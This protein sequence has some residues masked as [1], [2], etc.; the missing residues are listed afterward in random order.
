MRRTQAHLAFGMEVRTVHEKSPADPHIPAGDG[1]AALG[2]QGG[3]WSG[4]GHPARSPVQG[5]DAVHRHPG[6]CQAGVT[7]DPPADHADTVL[8][9]PLAAAGAQFAQQ[10]GTDHRRFT[11][12]MPAQVH[13]GVMRGSLD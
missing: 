10:P 3:C 9:A 4:A 2:L 13:H 12:L 5:D 8:D 1:L 11:V 6:D 7:F